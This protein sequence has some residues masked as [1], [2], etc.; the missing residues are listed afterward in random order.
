M[1][2][3]ELQAEYEDRYRYGECQTEECYEP[4]DSLGHCD[5]CVEEMVTIAEMLADR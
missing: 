1:T 5:A 4:A 3:A 2:D